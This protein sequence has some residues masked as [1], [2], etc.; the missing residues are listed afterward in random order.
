MD[1]P[2]VASLFPGGIRTRDPV[3]LAGRGAS[4]WRPWNASR[5]GPGD[6]RHAPSGSEGACPGDDEKPGRRRAPPAQVARLCDHGNPDTRVW[7][8]RCR[9][10]LCS[11]QRR[12]SAA[13]ALEQPRAGW[14]GL[15]DPAVR[16]A[17][18]AVFSRARALAAGDGGAHRSIRH[19]RP[20]P[21]IRARWCGRRTAGAR[22]LSWI[23][24]D[25]RCPASARPGLHQ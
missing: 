1:S 8:R 17:D 12:A 6:D 20:P 10:G 2:I 3:G 22:G 21:A 15:G 5:V 23:L 13:H 16:R 25:A 9:R 19:H 14:V 24:C 4:A 7:H 18:M 11:R